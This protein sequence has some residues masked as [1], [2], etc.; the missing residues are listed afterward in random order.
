MYKKLIAFLFLLG[1]QA[2][3]QPHNINHLLPDLEG[4]EYQHLLQIQSMDLQASGLSDILNF[5]K[6]NLEWLDHI[7]GHRSDKLSF[8]TPEN[9]RTY[10][11]EAPSIYNEE[12]IRA[13]FEKL[14]QE[15]PVEI[16]SVLQDGQPFTDNP[17][18][19]VSDYL[20]YGLKI[21]GVY[22]SAARWTLLSPY[23]PYLSENRVNDIRGYY[24]LQRLADLKG[25]LQNYGTLPADLKDKVKSWLL[26]IC[27]NTEVSDKICQTKLETSITQNKGDASL[28]YKNYVPQAESI[29]NKNYQIPASGRRNDIMWRTGNGG[30]TATIPFLETNETVKAYLHNIEQEW[31]WKNWKLLLQFQSASNIPYIEFVPGA[32]PHVNELGGNQIVMDANQPLTEWDSQWTIRHEFGHVLGFPDCYVEFYDSS[33][34]AIV[35][36]QLDVSDLM[37][38]RKGKLKENHFLEMKRNYSL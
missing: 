7:N 35:N 15:L 29:Y 33:L 23:I 8:S 21:D 17:P 9:R 5:G 24:H 20:R 30:E 11:V 27:Y 3:A 4:R 1:I 25:S 32:T 13:Q 12:M 31:Q 18:V 28:F 14:L 2:Y 19:A 34:H 36:Y 37:C 38:S 26:G 6:R 10:P 22:Q 16:K